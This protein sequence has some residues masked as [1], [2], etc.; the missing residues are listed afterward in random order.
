MVY[1]QQF[2]SVYGSKTK[3]LGTIFQVRGGGPLRFPACFWAK[4]LEDLPSLVLI[5]SNMNGI[6]YEKLLDLMTLMILEIPFSSLPRLKRPL[7]DLGYAF[8]SIRWQ[9][10][11][12]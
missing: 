8:M 5:C 6:I 11:L 9:I 10:D 2:L 7:I 12:T 3:L 4:S 1:L